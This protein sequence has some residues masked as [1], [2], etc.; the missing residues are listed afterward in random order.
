MSRPS[1]LILAVLLGILGSTLI[2]VDAATAAQKVCDAKCRCLAIYGAF[3]IGSTGQCCVA[4]GS[5]KKSK[6]WCTSA[7]GSR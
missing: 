6:V 5:G 1:V 3:W 2:N 7:G 4:T